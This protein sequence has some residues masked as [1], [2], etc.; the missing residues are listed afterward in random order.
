VRAHHFPIFVQQIKKINLE[1]Q[2]LRGAGE[3]EREES[4]TGDGGQGRETTY[5]FT[6][7]RVNNS[8]QIRMRR[9]YNKLALRASLLRATS[10]RFGRNRRSACRSSIGTS[11]TPRAQ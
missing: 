9:P 8:M 7:T 11:A 2:K 10:P 5:Q 3:G 1:N 4:A 6:T